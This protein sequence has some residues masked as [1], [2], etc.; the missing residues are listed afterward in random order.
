M[1]TEKMLVRKV[2][3]YVFDEPIESATRWI[4]E[5]RQAHKPDI[6]IVLSHI[7]IA[8]DRELAARV[9]G[10]DLI[11]GGHSHTVLEQGERVGGTLIVQTG[12]HARCLGKVVVQPGKDGTMTYHATLEAL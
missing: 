1:I 8:R 12:A 3:A 11:I 9:A 2:S 10:I 7:G 6:M 4:P 5:L